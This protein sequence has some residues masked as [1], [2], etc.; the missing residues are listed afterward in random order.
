M[1]SPPSPRPFRVEETHP[2][3]RRKKLLV[4]LNA[5]IRDHS[6][7]EHSCHAV[8]LRQCSDI[9]ELLSSPPLAGGEKWCAERTKSP[10]M[11]FSN[12]ERP[13]P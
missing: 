2:R 7:Y 5:M 13:E 10:G 6:S 3:R 11:G 12:D 8:T 1:L 4:I 9:A